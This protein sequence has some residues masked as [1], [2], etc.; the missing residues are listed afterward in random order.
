M[1]IDAP[2]RPPLTI[3]PDL[4]RAIDEVYETPEPCQLAAMLHNKTDPCDCPATHV[5]AASCG[6]DWLLCAGHAERIAETRR[7]RQVACSLRAVTC[8]KC[9]K[10]GVVACA[11]AEQIRALP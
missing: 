11:G 2:E 9:A 1:S 7:L 6:C 3:D 4:W 10:C 8:I 5:L